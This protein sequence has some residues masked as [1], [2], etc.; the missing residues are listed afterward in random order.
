MRIL[1]ALLVSG[2]AAVRMTPVGNNDNT[3]NPPSTPVRG[4]NPDPLQ[5]GPAEDLNV[6][7]N[8]EADPV[9]PPGKRTVAR[10]AGPGRKR[11]RED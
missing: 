1:V 7:F 6:D 5:I 10:S 4:P 11:K 3:G 2:V 8:L 9:T